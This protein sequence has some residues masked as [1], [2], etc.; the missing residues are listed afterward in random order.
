MEEPAKETNHEIEMMQEEERENDDC[1]PKQLP[2]TSFLSE[3]NLLMVLFSAFS[4]LDDERLN[5]MESKGKNAKDQEAKVCISRIH[6]NRREVNEVKLMKPSAPRIQTTIRD[7]RHG[8]R[9]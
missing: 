1:N 5:Y 4:L 3:L 6:S 2:N 7:S 9:M 8:R